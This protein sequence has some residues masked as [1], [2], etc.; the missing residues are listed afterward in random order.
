MDIKILVASHKNYRVPKDLT[1]YL[2]IFVGSAFHVSTPS[3]FAR[4]D[5]G[6]NISNKNSRYNEL[7]GLYWGGNIF[8]VI[9]LEWYIIE[10]TLLNREIKIEI[11]SNV[12]FLKTMLRII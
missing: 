5:L 3:N 11:S 7:T 1:L 9:I 4:D 6:D 2:P 12:C 10:D 8:P